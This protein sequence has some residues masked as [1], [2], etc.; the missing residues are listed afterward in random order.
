MVGLGLG[1]E[2]EREDLSKE[3]DAISVDLRAFER[4]GLVGSD[5]IA[6]C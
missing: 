5:Y 6:G 3:G 1:F 2:L 4:E